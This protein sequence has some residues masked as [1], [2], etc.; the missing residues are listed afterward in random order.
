[1]EIRCTLPSDNIILEA[2]YD[3]QPGDKAVVIT[4]PHP[5]MGGDMD[6]PV[7]DTIQKAY[8]G[9]GYATLRFNFRGTGRSGGS[10]D[11]GMGETHDVIAAHAFLT[12]EGYTTIDLAGYSFGAY[13]NLNVASK[14]TI[15]SRVV[16]VSPPVDF[17]D[18]GDLS[19]ASSL[20]LVVTGDEDS[21][22]TTPHIKKLLN[23]WNKSAIFKEISGS[24]HFYSGTMGTL[25][26]C[27]ND[28]L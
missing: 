12:K 18:F 24:D 11:N 2:R 23:N 13:V 8:A 26:R 22:A 21:Y 25:D 6:N 19:G 10:H 27:F 7:V 28:Y 9:K 17:M 20:Y 1:M 16:L 14:H 15:F 3:K 5:L 4:H